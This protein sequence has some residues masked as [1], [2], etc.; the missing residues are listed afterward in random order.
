MDCLHEIAKEN[1]QVKPVIQNG[2]RNR[3]GKTLQSIF[4][5]IEN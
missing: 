1:V 5:K 4:E 3:N 2:R